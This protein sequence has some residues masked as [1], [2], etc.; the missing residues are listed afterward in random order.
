MNAIEKEITTRAGD[1][2]LRL[3]TNPI[4]SMTTTHSF[5]IEEQ[6]FARKLEPFRAAIENTSVRDSENI[7]DKEISSDQAI[8]GTN[9]SDELNGGPGPQSL[10]GLNGN[11]TINGGPGKDSLE[12]GNGEDELHGSKGRDE[13]FGNNGND[14]LIGGEGPDYMNG[15]N[16]NDILFGGQAIDTYIGGNGR[17][18]FVIGSHEEISEDSSDKY[19][20]NNS[21]NKEPEHETDGEADLI[22]DFTQKVDR[23]ALTGDLTFDQI[24]YIPLGD[25]DKADMGI[26]AGEKILAILKEVGNIQLNKNDFIDISL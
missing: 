7:T 14:I 19:I 22:L 21:G 6:F 20:T 4:R 15:G 10:I 5:Q 9:K 23:I 17:D 13:I 3:P 16:G 18:I 24:I 11:D 25:N 8:V 12:G 2:T 26:Y 1:R